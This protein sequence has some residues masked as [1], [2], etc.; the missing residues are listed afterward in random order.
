MRHQYQGSVRPSP[1]AGKWYPAEREA[2]GEIVDSFLDYPK[3][4]EGRVY[5][6]LAPHA[7]MIY[8]GKVAGQAFCHLDKRHIDTVVVVG[9]SHYSYSAELLSTAH[10]YFST[11]LG[12]IPIALDLLSRIEK[13]V[14]LMRVADDPEHAIEMELPFLQ[15]R[16]V[17][18]QLVPLVM[19]DQSWEAAQKLGQ[20][21][22][23]SV[24]DERVLLV[25][26][27]DLS[28]FYPQ[29][30]AEVF[31]HALLDAVSVYDA[32]KVIEL[33]ENG[34]GFAC[35]RGAIAAVMVA[36][37]LMGASQA[38]VTGYATSGEVNGQF[39]RVVGYGAAVLH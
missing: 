10:H 3:A 15:R 25:A 30:Q 33:D 7:G 12:D 17:D 19:L 20:A 8:A 29:A 28:H 14:E 22:A 13:R 2:L 6:L 11:P 5:G 36:A 37:Q 23:D 32:Q 27:S 16:L 35:G 4:I 1:L 31:D 21:I 24:Q 18:F 34:Q 26:S 38:T 9:P 39:E